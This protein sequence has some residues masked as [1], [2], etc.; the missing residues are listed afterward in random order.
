MH[1][2]THTYTYTSALFK[3]VK[4]TDINDYRCRERERQLHTQCSIQVVCT[5]F[6]LKGYHYTYII[7][8]LQFVFSLTLKSYNNE[9]HV[10]RTLILQVNY[11]CCAHITDFGLIA[12]QRI[13]CFIHEMKAYK[14]CFLLK[15]LLYK[16]ELA[17]YKALNFTSSDYPI[18]H[19]RN[20]L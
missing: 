6:I 19:S 5:L 8:N 15:G 18:Q 14:I 3:G 4:Y 2:H 12:C 17:T 13:V 16:E 11:V 1:K 7:F 10:K 20:A 9:K